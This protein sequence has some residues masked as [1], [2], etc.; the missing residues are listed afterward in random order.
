MQRRAF[1]VGARLAG[2]SSPLAV[3]SVR[4]ER[5]L[6]LELDGAP[7]AAEKLDR[8]IEL[9]RECC[10]GIEFERMAG[11]T[12]GG[13]RLE[14]RGIDPDASLFRPLRLPA[15][16]ESLRA[17]LAKAT[18]LGVTAS[19]FVCC[20]LPVAAV[21]LLGAAAA[22]L[23]SLDGPVPI[24]AGAAVGGTLAWWWLGKRRVQSCGPRC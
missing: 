3:E 19:L 5:G 6:A 2:I 4:L 24:I 15:A 22:P 20:V 21:A 16:S 23:T 13:L 8:L 9:E 1:A 11:T 12:R 10:S 14:I 7:G 18:G 17:R